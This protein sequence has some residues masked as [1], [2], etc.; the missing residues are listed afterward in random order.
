LRTTHIDSS[1]GVDFGGEFGGKTW[2][3]WEAMFVE[4]LLIP[5]KS[6]K[7]NRKVFLT[8]SLTN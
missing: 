8:K 6:L 5:G 2:S 4:V 1:S 3:D 7:E